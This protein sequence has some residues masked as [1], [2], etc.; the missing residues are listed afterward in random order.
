MEN[1]IH[2]LK[3][4]QKYPMS[5]IVGLVRGPNALAISL[6]SPSQSNSRVLKKK[7][8]ITSIPNDIQ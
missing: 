1:A 6:I 3:F 5:S 4:L 8:L 2:G 7:T